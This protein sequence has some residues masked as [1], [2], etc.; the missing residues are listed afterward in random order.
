M[1]QRQPWRYSMDYVPGHTTDRWSRSLQ[2]ALRCRVILKSGAFMVIALMGCSEHGQTGV[3]L[4]ALLL[5]DIVN[6]VTGSAAA[7]LDANGQF[8]LNAPTQTGLPELTSAQA[9]D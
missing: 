4:A 5:K 6:S 8:R 9:N 2:R 3:V 7:A 1:H